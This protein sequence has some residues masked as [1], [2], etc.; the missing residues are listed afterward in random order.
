[1]TTTQAHT[2]ARIQI[3]AK[4][5]SQSIFGALVGSKLSRTVEGTV[6]GAIQ[7]PSKVVSQ[8]LAKVCQ[9]IEQGVEKARERIERADDV[10]RHGHRSIQRIEP[11]PM[12]H[13]RF[14]IKSR[15]GRRRK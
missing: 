9:R 7:V 5:S 12:V 8:T 4:A 3:H 15:F 10:A 11:G 6:G 13:S 14:G 2:P 1:M